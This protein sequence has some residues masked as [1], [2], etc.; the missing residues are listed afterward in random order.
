[1]SESTICAE[2]NVGQ[3]EEWAEYVN[4]CERLYGVFSKYAE[5]KTGNYIDVLLRELSNQGFTAKNEEE[6]IGLHR[7]LCEYMNNYGNGRSEIDIKK[8]DRQ[9]IFSFVS[10]EEEPISAK[11][12]DTRAKKKLIILISV[13]CLIIFGISVA[14]FSFFNYDVNIPPPQNTVGNAINEVEEKPTAEEVAVEKIQGFMDRGLFSEAKDSLNSNNFKL[15]SSKKDELKR[16]MY[17]LVDIK[18]DSL[19]RIIKSLI[20]TGKYEEAFDFENQHDKNIFRLKGS[21]YAKELRA[22]IITKWVYSHKGKHSKARSIKIVEE[23]L[24]NILGSQ[25]YFLSS[26]KEKN[27]WYFLDYDKHCKK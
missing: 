19:Q 15:N 5:R 9:L 22:S 14:V 20:N 24:H 7:Y 17:A 16:Q 13:V 8:E 6:I 23:R 21:D 18:T 25:C 11:E 10:Q 2:K 27:G 1:M 4:Y 12:V 3:S 26:Y